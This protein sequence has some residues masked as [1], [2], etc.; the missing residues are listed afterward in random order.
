MSGAEVQG[1]TAWN[2]LPFAQLLGVAQG[3]PGVVQGAAHCTLQLL[4]QRQSARQGAGQGATGAMIP[5]WQALAGPG[6]LLTVAAI[7]AVM[8]LCL[9]TVTAGDDSDIAT[10]SGNSG[11]KGTG[12]PAA[13][14]SCP[15]SRRARDAPASSRNT[16]MAVA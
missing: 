2:E 6:V 13:W 4:A 10:V 14:I 3:A 1:Q 5:P 16:R 15:G 12:V 11:S 8:D 9:V 7:K